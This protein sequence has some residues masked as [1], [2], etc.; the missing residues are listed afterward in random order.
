MGYRGRGV[1]DSVR[2]PR[3]DVARLTRAWACLRLR[4]L[5]CSYSFFSCSGLGPRWEGRVD[6][7]GRGEWGVSL[8]VAGSSFSLVCHCR[9]LPVLS[10]LSA[11]IDSGL[12]SP[13][14]L[15]LPLVV[16]VVVRWVLAGFRR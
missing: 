12:V 14:L 3:L 16:V 11:W 8:C 10:E 15:H 1:C 2:G 5:C 7:A 4:V 9:V 13:R 6:L